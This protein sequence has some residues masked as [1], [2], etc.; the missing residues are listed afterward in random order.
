ML[1]QL[2]RLKEASN[3]LDEDTNAD[4]LRLKQA[5][6]DGAQLRSQIIE[7]RPADT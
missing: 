7:A 4:K 2:A 5:Q 3:R 1:C 6:M